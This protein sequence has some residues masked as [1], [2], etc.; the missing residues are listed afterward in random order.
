MAF[1]FWQA[2]GAPLA[3]RMLRSSQ[4]AHGAL[5][6]IPVGWAAVDARSQAVR[7]VGTALPAWCASDRACAVQ[8]WS[9]GKMKE[10]ANNLVLF[11]KVRRSAAPTLV[12]MNV[13]AGSPAGP[14]RAASLNEQNSVPPLWICCLGNHRQG[15]SK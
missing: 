7:G 13:T 2:F 8:K 10:K 14:C 5:L 12:R 6:C 11:D 3:L 1:S 9:K 15:G 4:W